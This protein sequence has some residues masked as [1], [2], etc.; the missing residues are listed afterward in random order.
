MHNTIEFHAVS[1]LGDVVA[2]ELT[3]QEGDRVPVYMFPEYDEATQCFNFYEK[4][5][6]SKIWDWI[7]RAMV[8]ANMEGC[9]PHS[10]RASACVWAIRCFAEAEYVRAAGRWSQLGASFGKYFRKGSLLRE[11]HL[12]NSEED[13]IF[14]FWKWT[15]N[16]VADVDG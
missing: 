12:V 8:A 2:H 11:T 1:G 15:Y 13:P 4:A 14:R 16:V 9:T 10:I 5:G 7:N 3:K 6:T